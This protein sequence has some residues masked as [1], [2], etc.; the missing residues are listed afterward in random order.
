MD[1]TARTVSQAA[2]D[3][4]RLATNDAHP[5]ERGYYTLLTPYEG[6]QDSQDE[7]TQEV[8]WEKSLQWVSITAQDTAVGI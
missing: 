1:P 4:A 6:S 8:L 3:V 7:K 2:V 5:G